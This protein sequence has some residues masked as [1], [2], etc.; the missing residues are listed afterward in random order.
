[1]FVCVFLVC[2]CV[3]VC[4]RVS[5]CVCVFVRWCAHNGPYCPQQVDLGFDRLHLV[6]KTSITEELTT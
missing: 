5:V 3:Y 4:V 2:V 6:H 1:M